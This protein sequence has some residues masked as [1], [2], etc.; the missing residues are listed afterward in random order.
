MRPTMVSV[1][2]EP[3]K[4][5][6]VATFALYID[7]SLLCIL[8]HVFLLV[9]LKPWENDGI[10]VFGTLDICRRSEIE[11]ICCTDSMVESS[12]CCFCYY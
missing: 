1:A 2:K 6:R 12:R 8:D 10:L 5:L 3:E 9:S 11:A 4:Q 7:A